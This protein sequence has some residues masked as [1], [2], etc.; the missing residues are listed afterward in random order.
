MSSVNPL[1]RAQPSSRDDPSQALR[2]QCEFYFGDTN[3]AKDGFLRQKIEESKDGFVLISVLLT[4]NRLRSIT[5]DST[6][7]AKALQASE[8]APP[9]LP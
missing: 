4:F 2:T 3:L 9:S 7:V 8:E 6:V 1:A 5:E